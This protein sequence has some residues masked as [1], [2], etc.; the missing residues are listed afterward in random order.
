MS[1]KLIALIG[2]A[3]ITFAGGRYV[4]ISSNLSQA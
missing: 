1:N 2:A 3:P 4:V